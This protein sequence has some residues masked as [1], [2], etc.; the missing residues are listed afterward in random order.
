MANQEALFQQ[1]F[2]SHSADV[3]RFAFYL[4]G[5]R[6]QAEDIT[7]ETFV[8]AWT[9]A[10]PIRQSSVKAYLITIARNLYLHDLRRSSRRTSLDAAITM[11][12]DGNAQERAEQNQQFDAIHRSLAAVPEADRTALLLYSVESFSYAEIADM[13]EISVPAVKTRIFRARRALE[14]IRREWRE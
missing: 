10:T 7:S 5:D 11:S 2:T 3:F 13:L 14:A 12:A 8:R 6:D 9:S 1:I 4:C